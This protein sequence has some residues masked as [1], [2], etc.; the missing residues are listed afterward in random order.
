MT[1][2]EFN[3]FG[4]RVFFCEINALAPRLKCYSLKYIGV[5]QEGFAQRGRF[6][7]QHLSCRLLGTMCGWGMHVETHIPDDTIISAHVTKHSGTSGMPYYSKCTTSLCCFC[8]GLLQYYIF[9]ELSFL[10]SLQ[11]NKRTLPVIVPGPSPFKFPSIEC[12]QSFYSTHSEIL[13]IS[14]NRL[15]VSTRIQ[16][17]LYLQY[18]LSAINL[19][20]L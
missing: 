19:L 15:K 4:A 14:L 7:L 10:Q 11:K 13:I 9:L 2:A 20:G 1:R 6:P 16:C 17:L 8:N 12:N 3:C 18:I 5:I